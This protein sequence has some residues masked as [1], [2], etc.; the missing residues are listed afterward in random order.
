MRKSDEAQVDLSERAPESVRRDV[1][2]LRLVFEEVRETMQPLE[3]LAEQMEPLLSK[4]GSSEEMVES[5]GLDSR[6]RRF[7]TRTGR[8]YKTAKWSLERISDEMEAFA[9]IIDK[10]RLAQERETS[11]DADRSKDTLR[12]RAR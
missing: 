10:L 8:A 6:D 3:E 7:L 1:H 9:P 12:S 11:A 2:H 4:F 5:L